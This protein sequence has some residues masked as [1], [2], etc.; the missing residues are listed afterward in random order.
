MEKTGKNKK[1]KMKFNIK[2]IAIF[3]AVALVLIEGYLIASSVL[4][5]IN[6]DTQIQ[7]FCSAKCDYNPDSFLWEFSNDT[8]TK[9]FTTRDECF[10][11]CSQVKQG[12]AASLLNSVFN[13]I[14]K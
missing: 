5:K 13:L 9:G 6:N 2:I 3:L 12:F 4:D 11:Y 10:K 8:T 7:N 1:E 14:K